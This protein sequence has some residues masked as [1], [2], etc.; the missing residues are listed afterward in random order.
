[1]IDDLRTIERQALDAQKEGDYPKAIKLWT[2]L[3][4]QQA[5]WEHGYGCYYLANCFAS[6]RQFDEA[7]KYY[8]EAARIEPNDSLFSDAL[9]SLQEAKKAGLLGPKS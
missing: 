9:T 8:A 7:E 1:M 4:R 6:L 2:R 5:N 3:L